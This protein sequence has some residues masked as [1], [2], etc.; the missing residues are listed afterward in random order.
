MKYFQIIFTNYVRLTG[1]ICCV[2]LGVVDRKDGR[3]PPNLYTYIYI[4]IDIRIHMSMMVSTK[5]HV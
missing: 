1:R 4:F 5:G 3:A 2:Y